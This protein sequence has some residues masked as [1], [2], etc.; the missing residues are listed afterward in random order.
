MFND[1]ELIKRINSTCRLYFLESTFALN[2]VETSN[3]Y[4]ATGNNCS[5]A[6][7][8]YNDDRQEVNVIKWF[9]KFWIYVDIR[10][11]KSASDFPNT[12]ISISI[13]QGDELDDI[14]NQ[15]FRAEWDNYGNSTEIHPQPH[16]HIYPVEYPHQTFSD[17]I[18]L[19]KSY[20]DGQVFE[21]LLR[22]NK[23]NLIDIKKIHFAMYGQWASNGSHVNT[24]NDQES[25]INWF[26][27]VLHCIKTQIEYAKS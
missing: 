14:K 24:I 4:V 27:G 17:F 22:E 23:S 21:D 25:I 15:L 11:E 12:F 19:L 18:E 16:W 20:E 5:K 7:N 3:R 2:R 13:F 10:F 26:K 1:T 8:R 6:V 9:D